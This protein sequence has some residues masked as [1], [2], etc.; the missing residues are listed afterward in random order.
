M[1]E[2]LMGLQPSLTSYLAVKIATGGGVI[3]FSFAAIG[4]LSMLQEVVNTHPG[5][6]KQLRLNPVDYKQ[7]NKNPQ[8][9]WK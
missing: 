1:M 8:K 5:L 4:V 9:A 7:T 3:F 2:E 6:C